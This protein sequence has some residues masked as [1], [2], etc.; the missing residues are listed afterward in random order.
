MKPL[1]IIVSG[2]SCTG[3]TTLA[4]KIAQEFNLCLIGRDNLKEVLFDSLGW[5]D[6]E[7]SKKLGAA[8][9]RLL[10]YCIDVQLRVGQ[11]LI[12][13]SNFQPKFDNKYFQEFETKYQAD[14]L[15]IYC[16]TDPSILFQ[17]YQARA[18]SGQR[19][20]GHVDHLNYAEYKSNLNKNNYNFLA[21][22]NHIIEVDTTDF[23]SINYQKISKT[24]K[25]MLNYE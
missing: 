3:K 17:R 11:S 4:Q 9:Y 10:Y 21:V 16:K 8:S 24:I 2:F 15:Q 22:G 18:N 25:N 12:V 5:E 14:I 20:P 23:N 6:K 1:L 7:W 13:E 19:H